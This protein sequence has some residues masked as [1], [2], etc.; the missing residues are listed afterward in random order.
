MA[1][2]SGLSFRSPVALANTNQLID[3][4]LVR[5]LIID[6]YLIMYP[7]TVIR[8]ETNSPFSIS[9]FKRLF[10]L[11]EFEGFLKWAPGIIGTQKAF[12]G[13]KRQSKWTILLRWT[14]KYLWSICFYWRANRWTTRP[15]ATLKP[16]QTNA[17]TQK[18]AD[19]HRAHTTKWHVSHKYLWI[20]ADKTINNGAAYVVAS[21][22]IYAQGY[23][24][25]ILLLLLHM[26]WCLMRASS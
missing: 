3:T 5:A 7:C 21:R 18:H 16:R 13:G 17:Y 1:I 4:T 9:F 8:V 22:L 2:P 24:A 6:K 10:C 19:E 12:R 20:L 15:I 26:R 23:L 14:F 11:V 25:K